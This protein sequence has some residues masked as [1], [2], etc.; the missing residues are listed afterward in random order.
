VL[1][2]YKLSSGLI[3][4]QDFAEAV[5]PIFFQTDHEEFVYVSHGG[6]MFL[7]SYRGRA[8]GITCRHVFGDFEPS[9]LFVT[10]EK[11][12]K[13]GSKP[14]RVSAVAY[15]NSPRGGA[16]GTDV[17]DF[18]VIE[19]SDSPD[20]FTGCYVIDEGT[21]GTSKIGHSLRVAGVLKEK[22]TWLPPDI[23]IGYC[24]LDLRD[25][26]QFADAILRH[27]VGRFT[28]PQFSEI[29]GVSGS[30]IY[31]LTAHRLCGIV[32]RGGMRVGELF[33]DCDVYFWDFFDVAQFLDVVSRKAESTY[34]LKTVSP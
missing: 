33:A 15:P 11:D 13:K 17:E 21:V 4:R 23:R 2:T 25:A 3:I 27:A 10:Q 26:G 29:K 22:S 28:Q 14:A 20:F 34:Y 9:K 30:P 19:F 1:E 24:S 31:D 6:T 32:A 18:C 8:F 5:R 7:V 16:Q 12:A